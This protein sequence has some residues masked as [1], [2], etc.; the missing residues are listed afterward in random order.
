[1]TDVLVVGGGITGLSAAWELALAGLDVLLVESSAGLGGKVRTEWIDGH[2]VEH[3]PDSFITYKP[4]ALDLAREL[5]L[6][7]Q[8][9]SVQEPRAVALRVGGQMHPMPEGMGLVLPT[10]LGPFARTRILTWRQKLRAGGD[11]VL[12]RVLDDWDSSI[13]ALL[14]RRLGNGVVDRFAD[15]LL[16][17]IYG[18]RVDELSVDAVL[19][20]LRASEERHRSLIR[21]SWADGRAARRRG[22]QAGSPFRSLARGMGSLTDAL[23]EALAERGADLRPSTSATRLRPGR[24]GVLVELTAGEDVEVGQVV[25]ACGASAAARLVQPFAPTAA[26]ALSAI[27]LGSTASVTLGYDAAA[28]PQAPR[29]HGFLEAGPGPA[30][31]SGVTLSSNKWAG[32][33]PEGRVLVR[34]FVPE[35]VGPLAAAPDAEILATVTA[36]VGGVLGATTSPTLQHVVRWVGAMPKYVVGHRQR[37]AT[38]EAELDGPVRLAGSALNGV[39]IPDCIADGRRVARQAA[40]SLGAGRPEMEAPGAAPPGARTR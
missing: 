10:R 19:P 37:V 39:G 33:A 13:G 25:L 29:G 21:A 4:A 28:L 7:D 22:A 34:A 2:L 24:R 6:G 12:P 16:G 8:V 3:G 15:P 26:E 14:R 18:A 40:A 38:I 20:S 9:I 1:M 31:I 23:V 35:S 30:P 17:G 27:P 32:R 11:L 36:H 5:H